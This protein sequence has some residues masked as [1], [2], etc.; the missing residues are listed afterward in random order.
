MA[1]TVAVAVRKWLEPH[2][3]AG[4]AFRDLALLA[5]MVALAA[6]FLATLR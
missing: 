2:R 4:H 3:N 6:T 5:S 1:H